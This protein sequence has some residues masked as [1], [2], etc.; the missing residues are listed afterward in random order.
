M[1]WKNLK[2]VLEDYGSELQDYLKDELDK[3]DINAS[4]KLKESIKYTVEL[5]DTSIELDLSLLDY[6]KYVLGNGRGPTKN[7]GPGNVRVGIRQW[8]KDKGI[9]PTEMQLPDGTTYLPTVEQLPFMIT[10]KIHR[11][12]YKA[13]EGTETIETTISTL[14]AK[15]M[16]LIEDA[17]TKDIEYDFDTIFLSLKD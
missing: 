2:Q 10:R 7:N 16:P 15:Y 17:I 5:D 4:G 6:Y 11:E 13:K 8:V 14:E 9:Q 12:G 1:E 3:N